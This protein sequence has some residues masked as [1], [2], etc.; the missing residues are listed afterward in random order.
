MGAEFL[1][2]GG[3]LGYNVSAFTNQIMQ[4]CNL[5]FSVCYYFILTAFWEWL[6]MPRVIFF[7]Q[8]GRNEQNYDRKQE[9]KKKVME[10]GGER[11]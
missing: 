4:R 6:E 5:F 3:E 7:F 9:G 2:P 8:Y 1:S 11:R 10:E